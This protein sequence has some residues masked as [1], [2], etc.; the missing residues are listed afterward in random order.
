M[1]TQNTQPLNAIVSNQTELLTPSANTTFTLTSAANMVGKL[2][3]FINNGTANVVLQA[4]DSTAVATVGA[5]KA[6]LVTPSV[7]AP[8]TSSQWT[9]LSVSGGQLPLGSVVGTFPNLTGAYSCSATTVP[10]SAGYVLCQG[11]TISDSTSPMN[12]AV[13]PNINNG[14]FLAGY[15]A[16]GSTAALG[17][18][19]GPSVTLTNTQLP[20]HSHGSGSYATSLGIQ[21]G[22]YSVSGGSWALSGAAAEYGHAHN[23]QGS[24]YTQISLS[25]T[26]Q[27]LTIGAYQTV[28][29]W[30]ST[31]LYPTSGNT[32]STGVAETNGMLI[33]G[34]TAA[35][36]TTGYGSVTLSG[37]AASLSGSAPSLTGSN[38]V[39]GTSSSAG[40]GSSF[41]ILP[42]YL[43]AVYVMRAR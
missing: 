37:S 29:G 23:G 8:S 25:T 36:S 10:D 33:Y 3:T 7:D 32:S 28:A 30:T 16:S 40:S 4:P 18:A 26:A 15:T 27:Q 14:T 21:N 12:G 1:V 43:T 6:V 11:Q 41:S 38:S 39:S 9:N 24:L 20:S 31:R 35:D 17:V 22:A 5:G 2:F 42:T 13:I 19:A 34:T